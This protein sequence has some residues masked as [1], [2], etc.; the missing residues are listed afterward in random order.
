M[1]RDGERFHGFRPL[2][3]PG[4]RNHTDGAL[5]G[6]GNEGTVW[7]AWVPGGST[8][9]CRLLFHATDML[10]SHASYRGFGFLLRCLSE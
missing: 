9:A 8:N 10:P 6:V 7:S 1:D 2:P 4:Y 3:A 5:L